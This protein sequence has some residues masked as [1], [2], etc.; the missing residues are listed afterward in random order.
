MV[1][2]TTVA[3]SRRVV[4]GAVQMASNDYRDDAIVARFIDSNTGTLTI[5]VAGIGRGDTIAACEFPPATAIGLNC[6]GRQRRQ[7]TRRRWKL[8]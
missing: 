1:D 7:A 5:I 2:S 4:A 3:Q 6:S 8:S